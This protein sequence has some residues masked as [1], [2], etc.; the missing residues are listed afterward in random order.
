MSDINFV[1]DGTLE[2][3]LAPRSRQQVLR[4]IALEGFKHKL[5]HLRNNCE[6]METYCRDLIKSGG[7]PTEEL[8]EL[9][10]TGHALVLVA[11]LLKREWEKANG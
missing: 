2:R 9:E 5:S 10:Q 4:D 1:S 8:K 3:I 11:L 7:D 6:Q